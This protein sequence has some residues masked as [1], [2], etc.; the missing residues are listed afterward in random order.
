MSFCGSLHS[1]CWCYLC[2][3][4]RGG[5][6]A[7]EKRLRVTVSIKSRHGE[8]IT[9]EGGCWLIALGLLVQHSYNIAINE[10]GKRYITNDFTDNFGEE[11]RVCATWVKP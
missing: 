9:N 4:S 5:V 7:T 3:T 11:V 6:M 1:G 2:A 8:N 10:P